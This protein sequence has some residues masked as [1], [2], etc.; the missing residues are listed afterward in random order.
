MGDIR[1]DI[2]IAFTCFGVPATVT[3]PSAAPVSTTVVWLAPVAVMTDGV[4]HASTEPLRVCALLRSAV[5][6]VPR[7]T[8]IAAAETSGGAVANWRVEAVLG[9]T[10][11]EIRVAVIPEA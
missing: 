3:L 4:L 6:D 1:P 8:L 2:G 5:P 7:G 10:A 11:E 9:R